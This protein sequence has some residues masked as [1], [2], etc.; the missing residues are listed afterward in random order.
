M[1][2]ARMPAQ[3][4]EGVGNAGRAAHADHHVAR[5]AHPQRAIGSAR[6]HAQACQ[7]AIAAIRAGALG[8]DR[9]HFL[10]V[11]AGVGKVSRNP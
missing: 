9:N 5:A 11:V 6:G 1:E 8:L 3:R 10:A 2:H 7:R 4:H